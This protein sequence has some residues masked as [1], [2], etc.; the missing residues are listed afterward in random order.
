MGRPSFGF[1]LA[2]LVGI[3]FFFFLLLVSGLCSFSL[4]KLENLAH[5]VILLFLSCARLEGSPRT[6]HTCTS[7]KITHLPSSKEQKKV[8]HVASYHQRADF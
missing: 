7:S 6:C 8:L 3:F 1:E 4:E 2:R 5:Q